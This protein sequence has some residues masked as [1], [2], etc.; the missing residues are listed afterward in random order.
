MKHLL[1]LLISILLLSSPVIGQETGVLFQYETSSGFVWKTFG[2]EKLQPKYEGEITNGEPN[3]FGFMTYPYDDKSIVGEWKNGKEWDTKHTKKDGTLLGK[4]ENGKKKLSW[5]VLFSGKRN[6]KYGWYED[7]D[8]KNDSKYEGEIKNGLP[9][10][11]GT[12]IVI[13]SGYKYVGEWRNGKRNGR[14]TLTSPNGD[15]YVGEY[16]NGSRTGQGTMTYSDGSKYVGEWKDSEQSGQ[17]TVT[18]SDGNKYV[19]GWKDGEY[20]GQGTYTFG[21][22]EFEGDKYVGE[23]KNGKPNG[24]GTRTFS[25]GSKYV[26][27][28]KDGK[29]HGQGTYTWTDGNKTVGEFK[30]GKPWNSI[31]YDKNGY[32][33]VRWINGKFQEIIYLYKRYVNGL[34]GWYRHGDEKK[35]GKYEGEVKNEEPNGHGILINPNGTKSEGEW[36]NGK[37]WKGTLY[38][39]NGN[40]LGKWVNGNF[41]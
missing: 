30:L 17:G 4:F 37:I 36:T 2:N 20:H 32:K 27:E 22:G 25:D 39:K 19:G 26:G 11:K 40:I 6:G 38:D 21:K 34:W 14:G 29:E 1:I 16:R 15:E 13:G 5:G 33:E 10:G 41:N 18:F 35:D 7:G 31:G 8:D 3:G 24:Q 23:W 28:F 9:H 12:Q